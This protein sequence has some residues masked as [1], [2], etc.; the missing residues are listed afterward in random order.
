MVDA[1][2]K[3]IADSAAFYDVYVR[4]GGNFHFL[5]Q[6]YMRVTANDFSVIVCM[7]NISNDL[8]KR[9]NIKK[10]FQ[11][12]IILS[13]KRNFGEY[14]FQDIVEHGLT[15]KSNLVLEIVKLRAEFASRV[16]DPLGNVWCDTTS[17]F[18]EI[19]RAIASR[20][21]ELM[22]ITRKATVQSPEKTY[23]IIQG[24]WPTVEIEK[25]KQFFSIVKNTAEVFHDLIHPSKGITRFLGNASFRCE[26]GFHNIRLD[27]G[28]IY[29]S[30]R[31]VDK[32]FIGPDAFVQVGLNQNTNTVWY[33]G[34]N[35][36][37]V[38]TVVQNW[39]Y[40]YL[41]ANYII[42]SHVYEKNAP[43]T[44]NMIPCVGLEEVD[45][46]MRVVGSESWPYFAVNLKGHGTTVFM[47]RSAD[48]ENFEFEER[49]TPEIM[50]TPVQLAIDNIRRE[51]IRPKEVVKKKIS[52][53][54]ETPI[55]EPVEKHPWESKLTFNP[56]AI[57]INGIT[58]IIYRAIGGDMLS[59]WGLA[60]SK[61]GIN[62]DKRF[63]KPIFVPSEKYELPEKEI[64]DRLP[65]ETGGCEDP[66]VLGIFDSKILMSYTANS[67]SPEIGGGE[68]QLA[69]ASI[70]VDDFVS[71][72]SEDYISTEEWTKLWK[73]EITYPTEWMKK[74]K[75][76]G[77]GFTGY[78]KDGILLPGKVNG[79]YVLIHRPYPDIHITYAD[80]LEFP[81]TGGK[82]GVLLTAGELSKICGTK[83]DKIG[84]GAQ[85]IK[86]KYGWLLICHG[87]EIPEKE[88]VPEDYKYKRNHKPHPPHK[89]FLFT[90]LL[91][92]EN[93]EKVLDISPSIFMP[94]KEWEKY[95]W[96]NNVV[97]A[98]ATVPRYKDS[99]EILEEND[100]IL[101]YYGAADKVTGVAG[102]SI[103]DLIPEE[104]R[105][106]IT[107]SNTVKEL[108][109][110]DEYLLSKD[111]AENENN[112]N[113][114][115]S[116]RGYP[117]GHKN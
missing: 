44:S 7:P 51:E 88:E 22:D 75:K 21:L 32:R 27:D 4:N 34:D 9:I 116:A 84:G 40:E 36:P 13:S 11:K 17:D 113:L 54:S 103:K 5:H 114:F 105:K 80:K 70:N 95:G 110:I 63:D 18:K 98:A 101:I 58:Y 74:W 20:S 117:R 96:V 87:K 85:A 62:I 104:I 56:G 99:D 19:G 55:I 50:T 106:D 1:I 100:K 41:H 10:L 102:A 47:S 61:D 42:H 14:T 93:P 38:D 72:A 8:P 53:I 65:Y 107:F 49:P 86:T 79:K 76:H 39:L 78:D 52:R 31:N 109:Q 82:G 46:I 115:S 92:L 15:L 2:S 57:R 28:R 77:L 37:S 43:F 6:R 81:W 23:P 83:I 12:V 48:F 35:K 3:G 94:E 33:R 97:F 60:I 25:V 16:L 29:V 67:G 111:A 90:M 71:L 66:H 68:S 64:F 24:K 30:R 89:Y 112:E 45:D 69:F 91:D 26:R 59:R 108:S 73:N